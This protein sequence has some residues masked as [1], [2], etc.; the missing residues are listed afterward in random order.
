MAA[1]VKYSKVTE[2]PELTVSKVNFAHI[3]L[4]YG[5]QLVNAKPRTAKTKR[6][7]EVRGSG[8]KVH[9]QKGTGLS[10]QGESRNPH[11]RGGVKAHG[12]LPVKRE[13]G[14]NKKVRR[15]ALHSALKYHLDRGEVSLLKS[16]EFEAYTRTS[17]AYSALVRSGYSGR[18]IVV[19]PEGAV[20]HRALRNIAGISTRTPLC[21]ST[22]DLVDANFIIFTERALAEFRAFL[23]GRNKEIAPSVEEET[24]V[25][26]DV[27]V[28][29]EAAIDEEAAQPVETE[30]GGE[31]E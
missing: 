20:V 4:A 9:R 22:G 18:G 11:M 6:L 25:E 8:R 26:T 15:S 7:F 24:A 14:L 29:V 5:R 30:G 19:V 21:I 13:R 23:G 16:S 10:R 17:D 2:L 3:A 27:E 28:E 1:K 12:P 31:D